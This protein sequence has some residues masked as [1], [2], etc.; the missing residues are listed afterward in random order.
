MQTSP[1]TFT[2]PQARDGADFGFG[3]GPD[4]VSP[5][6]PEVIAHLDFPTP[7]LEVPTSEIPGVSRGAQLRAGLTEAVASVKGAAESVGAKATEVWERVPDSMK[8]VIIEAGRGALYGAI[9]TTPAERGKKI[10]AFASNPRG[11]LVS[12]AKD[13]LWGGINGA[14]IASVE[15]GV[16]PRHFDAG[17]RLGGMA[18]RAMAKRLQTIR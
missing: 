6:V 17:V 8:A 9:G 7:S 14:R 16:N 1:G 5:H 18:P 2:L 12:S 13:G 15:R 10:A 3:I 4:S 11:A